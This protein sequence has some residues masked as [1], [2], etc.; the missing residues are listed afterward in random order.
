MFYNQL[1]KVVNKEQFN[2]LKFSR[3]NIL[4]N[5]TK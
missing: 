5:I 4:S 1:V 3:F 2:Y